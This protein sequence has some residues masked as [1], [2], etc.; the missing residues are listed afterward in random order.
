MSLRLPQN[1]SS[2][3]GPDAGISA[4][5]SE[6]LAEKAAALGRAGRKLEHCLAA[7]RS[8]EDPARRESLLFEAAEAAYSY[9]IQ[10]EL[11]GLADHRAIIQDYQIPREVMARVGA[12]RRG[13][14]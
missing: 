10:R 5:E 12:R 4:F 13:E 1:L 14:S 8:N 11:C 9:I 2:G 7:L 6:V 3:I